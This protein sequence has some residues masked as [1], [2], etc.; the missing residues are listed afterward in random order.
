MWELHLII[1]MVND[2]TDCGIEFIMIIDTKPS[3]KELKNIAKVVKDVPKQLAKRLE[4]SQHILKQRSP[5]PGLTV[6]LHWTKNSDTPTREHLLRCVEDILGTR[7][8]DVA[9][10]RAGLKVKKRL[11]FHDQ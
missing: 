5:N 4:V 9:K 1:Y 3:R 10:L 8:K 11:V 7:N 6:L 2:N